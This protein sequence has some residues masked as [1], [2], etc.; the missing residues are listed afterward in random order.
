MNGYS[1]Q[2]KPPLL[3]VVMSVYNM[4]EYLSG[5]IE[6]VLSQSFRDFELI[7]VNDGSTDSSPEICRRYAQRDKRIRIIDKE[8][9]GLGSARQAGMDAAVE[10]HHLSRS[11][12]LSGSRSVPKMH[13]YPRR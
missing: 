12:R 3:S 5:G 10:I 4:S 6:S 11:G 8:N 13:R 2:N 1:E 7:L 9:G